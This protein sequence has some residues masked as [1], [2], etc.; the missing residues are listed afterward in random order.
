MPQFVFDPLTGLNSLLHQ[1]PFPSLNNYISFSF[2]LFISSVYYMNT[3]VFNNGRHP[4]V[5]SFFTYF[6]NFIYAKYYISLSQIRNR[7]ARNA[8]DVNLDEF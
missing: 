1:I 8:V 6:F 2:L 3:N 4:T 7:F 5:G